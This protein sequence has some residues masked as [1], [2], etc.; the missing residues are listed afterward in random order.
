MNI[1]KYIYCIN[2]YAQLISEPRSSPFSG[3]MLSSMLRKRIMSSLIERLQPQALPESLHAF[4]RAL[5]AN[6]EEV[7]ISVDRSGLLQSHEHTHDVSTLP[8]KE[9]ITE[10]AKH[11]QTMIKVG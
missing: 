2:L 8:H 9:P 7:V 6:S 1:H 5:S 4:T 3:K 11:I 10:M